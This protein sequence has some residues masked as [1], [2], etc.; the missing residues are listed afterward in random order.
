M[1]YRALQ[2]L[3]GVEARPVV[4]E[5]CPHVKPRRPAPQAAP[6]PPRT[7]SH[8]NGTN[9]NLAG[10]V[11]VAALRFGL[12][13]AS[14]AKSRTEASGAVGAFKD[15]KKVLTN[16]TTPGQ[17]PDNTRCRRRDARVS[18]GQ[19]AIA[20]VVVSMRPGNT[21]LQVPVDA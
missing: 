20:W 13:R 21:R 1:K 19:G 4:L 12:R 7:S 11:A 2:Q 17:H 9:V 3:V 18:S 8:H 6:A 14:R 5:P 16:R 15:V 10:A